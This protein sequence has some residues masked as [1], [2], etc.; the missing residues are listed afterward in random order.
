MK[1]TSVSTNSPPSVPIVAQKSPLGHS[2]GGS[3]WKKASLLQ[4]FVT[5]IIPGNQ[6]SEYG[7]KLMNIAVLC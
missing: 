3:A 2:M 6:N 4:S 1:L 5:G 7:P